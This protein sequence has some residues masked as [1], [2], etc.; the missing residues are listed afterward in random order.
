MTTFSGQ[1]NK[2][3]TLPRLGL[4]T[5]FQLTES[6]TIHHI[7]QT[8]QEESERGVVLAQ[9]I[10]TGGWR[11]SMVLVNE[12]VAEWTPLEGLIGVQHIDSTLFY[13]A[14]LLARAA[15]CE[16]SDHKFWN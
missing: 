16:V 14:I 11:R 3:S 1:F 5:F 10:D 7:T 9:K 8:I 6:I 13:D 15:V 2:N 12:V 4:F